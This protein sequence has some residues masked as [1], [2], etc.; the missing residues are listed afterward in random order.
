MKNEMRLNVDIP[1]GPLRFRGGG[2]AASIIMV[3]EQS[4]A[5]F[6]GDAALVL[7]LGWSGEI[8]AQYHRLGFARASTVGY[9]APSLVETIEAGTYWE[10]GGDGDLGAALDLGAG[11]QRL[12]KQQ[13]VLGPWKLALRGWASLSWAIS[14]AWIWRV[15]AEAYS[16]PFAP[17]GAATSA[18][19]RYL[20]VSAGLLIRIR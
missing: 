9:F 15:E 19:W 5:R 10:W 20:S 14:P 13:E 11:L 16:A 2:R 8:S 17:V 1:V 7:P 12:A 3:G 6:Q 4:N 18:D